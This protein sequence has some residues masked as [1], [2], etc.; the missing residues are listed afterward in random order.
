MHVRSKLRY[1][2]K[3]QVCQVGVALVEAC[4]EDEEQ[5]D[6]RRDRQRHRR[7]DARYSSKLAHCCC[8]ERKVDAKREGIR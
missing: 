7:C 1:L 8:S 5:T 3:V 6:Q 4:E 2:E